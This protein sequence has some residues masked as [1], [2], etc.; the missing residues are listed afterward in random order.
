[1]PRISVIFM[2]VVIYILIVSLVE[3]YRSSTAL[4]LIKVILAS[5][6]FSLHRNY[7]KRTIFTE[8]FRIR[9]LSE[10][11]RARFFSL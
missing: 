11:L 6:A 5:Y 10:L 4:N 3:L 7:A 8:G 9:S 2:I 1:M